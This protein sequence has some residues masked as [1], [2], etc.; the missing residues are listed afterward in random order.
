MQIKKITID[1]YGALSGRQFSLAEGMNIIEGHNESGKSTILSFIRFMLYGMPRKS[2]GTVT[3]RDR[4]ISWNGGVAGGSMEVSVPNKNGEVREYRVERHGQ[5]RGAAGHENYAEVVKIIDLATG[6]EAFEGEEPGKALLGLSQETFVSTAFIRQM[7]CSDVDGA[8]VNASIENLLFAAN[9]GINTEKAVG[10]LDEIRKTLLYKNE[11][12]GQIFE[13]EAQ[14]L[15]LEEKLAKAKEQAESIIAKEAAVESAMELESELATKLRDCENGINLYDACSILL[16]FDELHSYEDEISR[17][18]KEIELL[19]K[20]K[21][22]PGELPTKD[23]VSEAEALLREL[24]DAAADAAMKDAELAKVKNAPCGDRDLA[25]SADTIEAEGGTETLS[26]RFN[27]LQAKKKQGKII[28]LVSLI[29]GLVLLVLGGGGCLLGLSLE[30]PLFDAAFFTQLVDIAAQQLLPLFAQNQTVFVAAFIFVAI[31]GL[32]LVVWGILLSVSAKKT[33]SA[34]LQLSELAGTSTL[35]LSEF[36]A[37]MES[38]LKNRDLCETYDHA[39]AHAQKSADT[40]KNRLDACIKECMHALTEF[41]VVCEKDSV[42]EITAKLRDTIAALSALCG[43][44]ERLESSKNNRSALAASLAES[45]KSYNENTL[46]SAI[47]STDPEELVNSTDIEKAQTT[48]RY[49]KEQFAAATSKRIAMEKELI[50]LTA[51]AE[52]PAKIAARLEDI[53]EQLKEKRFQYQSLMLAI[54]S[55]E[56]ASDSLRRSVTPRI[57]QKAG[58]LMGRITDGK[59]NELGVTADMTVNIFA[60]NSTRSI[61]VLSKGTRDAA[62][63]SLRMALADLVSP[64]NPL[65]LTMDEG[66]SL[67]DEDRAARVLRLLY[68]Y[69]QQGGQCIL[70]TCHKREGELMRTI[71]TYQ[72]ILLS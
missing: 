47:G 62:Y 59:Y 45:L 53:A 6:A 55:I 26:A 7:E 2:S 13:L 23:T 42:L 4:G 33:H 28:G 54:D 16:R 46:R 68:D 20:E 3:E 11:K 65:P 39:L 5:L 24:A 32:G 58:L 25:F 44:R 61:D 8:G 43:E 35:S 17:L 1:E 49:Q 50:A 51:A 37:H 18:N 22:Y 64:G 56:S 72:H 27:R 70:F 19:R 60:G 71:G 67:L 66:L 38:C 12:G 29:L 48:R 31:L 57:R 41:G 40:G 30:A 21:G 10:K 63:L 9:E 52:N 36:T 15:I 14:K 34:I 69:A